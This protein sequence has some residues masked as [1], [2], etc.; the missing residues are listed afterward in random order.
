MTVYSDFD[1]DEPR[2]KVR[3]T[4]TISLLAYPLEC[5]PSND[6]RLGEILSTCL[7]G[8]AGNL[9]FANEGVTGI[10]VGLE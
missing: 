1:N 6:G 10:V 4:S 2:H 7:G 5:I 9:P 3:T 8:V